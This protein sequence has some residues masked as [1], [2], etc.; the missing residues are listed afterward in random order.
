MAM[1]L[2]IFMF[3]RLQSGWHAVTNKGSVR[4]NDF[5]VEKSCCFGDGAGAGVA[6]AD[7]RVFRDVASGDR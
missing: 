5:A 2:R 1:Y 4:K 3:T 6:G 7:Q